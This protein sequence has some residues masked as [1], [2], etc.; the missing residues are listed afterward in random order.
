MMEKSSFLCVV[1]KIQYIVFLCILKRYIWWT[2]KM[3]CAIIGKVG[4]DGIGVTIH[5]QCH[6]CKLKNL[7]FGL[8]TSESGFSE[9]IFTF[10]AIREPLMLN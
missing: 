10:Q 4:T 9:D 7:M 5:I 3:R 2:I 8:N 1:Q 6:L